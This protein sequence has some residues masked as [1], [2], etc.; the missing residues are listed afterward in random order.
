MVAAVV[1]VEEVVGVAGVVEVEVEMQAE[2]IGLAQIP[3]KF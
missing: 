2:K 3:S 1:E